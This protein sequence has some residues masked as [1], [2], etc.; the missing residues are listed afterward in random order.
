MSET[1]LGALI[2][3]AVAER[4]NATFVEE[5]V[6]KHIDKLVSAAVDAA[7]RQYSD[8]GK[9]ITTAVED[10]LRVNQLDLP[11]YGETVAAILKRQIETNVAELVAGRLAADMDDLLS[12]APKTIKLSKIAEDMLKDSD[13][14]GDDVISV[15]VEDR[16]GSST[17]VGLDE[18]GGKRKFLNCSCRILLRADGTIASAYVDDRHV[19]NG[20][21]VYGKGLTVGGR[22]GLE[23]RILAWYACGTKIE[24]D[25]D[26]VSTGRYE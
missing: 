12:L 4:L 11:S 17:W 8:T 19:G 13:E 7:L 26:Y 25:E 2:S 14:Y 16:S 3:E 5:V 21:R 10:A 23:Q 6:V 1:N 9:A 24:I 15:V 20:G 18:E 22:Y